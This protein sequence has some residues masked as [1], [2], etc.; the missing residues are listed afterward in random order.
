MAECAALFRPTT[1]GSPPRQPQYALADDVALDL[2]GAAGDRV[3]P[4]AEHA[5]RPARRVGDQLRRRFQRRVGAEQGAGKIGDAG[6]QLRAEQLQD[7]A[8]GPRRLAAQAAAHAAQ[9]GY[10]ERLRIDRELRQLLADVALA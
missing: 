7:R 9:P 2:A 4:R 6:R 5:V 8:F 3:L 1:T 10:L